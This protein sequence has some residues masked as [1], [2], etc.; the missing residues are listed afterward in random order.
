MGYIIRYGHDLP[1]M[2]SNKSEHLKTGTIIVTGILA[3]AALMICTNWAG[4]R[5]ILLPGFDEH[6]A[7]ML[8]ELIAQLS[9][10]QPFSDTVSA[11]CKEIIHRGILD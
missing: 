9:S 11:F 10:G 1:Y 2:R 8:E 3:I 5:E 4:A 6:T 7:V